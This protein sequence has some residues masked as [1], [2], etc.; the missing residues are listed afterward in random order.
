[1]EGRTFSGVPD[2]D[3]HVMGQEKLKCG[4][5]SHHH[6]SRTGLDKLILNLVAHWATICY[7]MVARPLSLVVRPFEMCK[8]LLNTYKGGGLQYMPMYFCSVVLQ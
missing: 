5:K 8:L 2:V 3:V 1:M 6:M 4:H 7:N